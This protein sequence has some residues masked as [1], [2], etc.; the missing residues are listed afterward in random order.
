MTL[1]YEPEIY[2][3]N[4]FRKNLW[5]PFVSVIPGIGRS[6]SYHTLWDIASRHHSITWIDIIT[7]NRNCSC[8]VFCVS[9]LQLIA[10][11]VLYAQKKTII[12]QIVGNMKNKPYRQ[13]I[14][15]IFL[16][17]EYNHRSVKSYE[18]SHSHSFNCFL[19]S[20]LEFLVV[21]CTVRKTDYHIE[22]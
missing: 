7:V 13:I 1:Q 17:A 16:K 22:W 11:Y 12:W 21:A 2:L 3:E 20:S 6:F 5:K 8:F 4:I 9:T 10:I 15:F 14:K 19:F 18:I